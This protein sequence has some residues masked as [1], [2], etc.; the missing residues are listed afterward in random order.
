MTNN[1][2][3]AIPNMK[4]NTEYDNSRDYS[5]GL[6]TMILNIPCYQVYN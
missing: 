1:R 2:F 3:L 4:I 6:I 5:S